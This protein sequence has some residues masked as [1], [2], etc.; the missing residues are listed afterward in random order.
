MAITENI[1]V[2]IVALAWLGAGVLGLVIHVWTIVIAFSV[3]GTIGAVLSLIF[4]VGAEIVWFTATG[5]H[6]GFGSVYCVTII[7]YLG[8]VGTCFGVL[9]AFRS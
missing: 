1:V 6:D 9:N 3:S 4:P 2:G 5:I 7:V 8:L